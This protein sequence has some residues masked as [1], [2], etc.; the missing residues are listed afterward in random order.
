MDDMEKLLKSMT[1]MK[2]GMET[3][4][5]ELAG[6]VEKYD[7][8]GVHIEI[9]GDGLVQNLNFQ[10]GTAPAVLE[11]VINHANAKVKEFITARMN[12]ITPPELR[13]A[14]N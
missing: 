4:Q 2:D 5:K 3:M 11:S 14:G 1:Q 6:Y 10:A 7:E 8:A 12:A 13:E 9:R